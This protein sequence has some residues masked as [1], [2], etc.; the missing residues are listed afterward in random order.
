ML[1][2]TLRQD[3]E[4]LRIDRQRG[5]WKPSAGNSA[6]RLAL[7]IGISSLIITGSGYFLLSSAGKSKEVEVVTV[8]RAVAT[9]EETILSA[10]GHV[11][12][13]DKVEIGSNASGIVEFICEQ[14]QVVQKGQVVAR[15]DDSELQAQMLQAKA[16]L[17]A[18]Q[19]KLTELQ[20]GSRRQEIAQARAGVAQVEARLKSARANLQRTQQLYNAG[21]VSRQALDDA[22][23]QSD[24]AQAERTTAASQY[25]MV[26]LG[27]RSEEL[28]QARSQVELA[29]ANVQ[30]YAA[31]LDK[32]VI[33]APIS[34]IVLERFV[35][36]GEMVTI[37]FTGQD[38]GSAALLTLADPNDLQVELDISEKDISKVALR[39]PARI[40]L[41]AYADNI[42]QGELV[43]FSPKAN[44]EK[45]TVQ[46]K[47]K[48]THPDSRWR[49]EMTAQVSLIQ[50]RRPKQEQS[51]LLIPKTAVMSL[52][53]TSFVFV[54][55]DSRASARLVK[56]GRELGGKVEIV[57]GL[58]DRDT[59]I[60]SGRDHLTDGEKI[61]VKN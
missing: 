16:G 37:S 56:T 28:D 18:A 14:G 26:N 40:S 17:S 55:K 52:G 59:V 15:L 36:R 46:I 11:S 31:L 7:V 4:S 2:D 6:R 49:P 44:R 58:Q 1:N 22:E 9:P 23:T 51:E 60:V 20:A 12:A 45:G 3:L 43:E 10:S 39:Q 8:F 29:S 53:E 33:R 61:T 41:D 21:L 35:N 27:P 54:V 57:E 38:H 50:E 13:R 19:I 42:Y 34:G 5:R 30:Y 25:E 32:K 24:V 47:V 48:V